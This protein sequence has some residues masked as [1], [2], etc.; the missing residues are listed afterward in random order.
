MSII[1]Q[2]ANVKIAFGTSESS[3]ETVEGMELIAAADAPLKSVDAVFLCLPH[4]PS[5]ATA[6]KGVSMG[7]KVI[8]LSADLRMD[9]TAVYK[10]WYG[11]EH[12]APQLLPAPFGLPEINRPKLIN[13]KYVANPG[14]HVTA[15]LLA[16]Y[17]LVKAKALTSD[18]IIADTKTGIS[19]A[20]KTL[21]LDSMFA[22]VYG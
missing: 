2:H 7:V 16:L 15:T 10:T 22:E 14:C 19:G 3:K 21:K 17:P 6:A 8:D 18:P 11:Q 20:G 5:G 12:P 13:A 1:A 4:G 9:S